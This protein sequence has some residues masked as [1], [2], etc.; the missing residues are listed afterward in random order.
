DL[1]AVEPPGRQA[2]EN[3]AGRRGLGRRA[4]PAEHLAAEAERAD[5]QA[6]HV[7]ERVD[8][9]AEPAAHADA[10]IAA[11]ER[12]HAEAR[13]YVVP[14][15]LAAAGLDPGDVLARRE[16]ER[17]G[18]VVGGGRLLALPAERRRVA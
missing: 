3:L 4:E 7:V 10:G 2:H 5:L 18:R 14:Q 17:H 16:P 12:L 9:A 1:G 15:R 6:L 13:V 11:H 8:L